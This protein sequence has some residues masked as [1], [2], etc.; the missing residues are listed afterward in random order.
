M[1]P[2]CTR[3]PR[4]S[5]HALPPF[6]SDCPLPAAG[7][8][9]GYLETHRPGISVTSAYW[10]Q[11]IWKLVRPWVDERIWRGGP[12]SYYEFFDAVFA[13]LYLLE[14]KK[15]AGDSAAD[16]RRVGEAKR[17]PPACEPLRSVGCTHPTN[18]RASAIEFLEHYGAIFLDSQAQEGIVGVGD[19]I[20]TFFEEESQRLR[21]DTMDI[22]GASVMHHQLISALAFVRYAKRRLHTPL[23][24]LGGFPTALDAWQVMVAFPF[25]DIAVFGDGE[26]TL[27]EICDAWQ[28]PDALERL[29]STVVR[30]AD[31][32]IE[33]PARG[34]VNAPDMAFANY[35]G[36][37]WSE[38]GQGN[39]SHLMLPICNARGCPWG[40]CGFCILNSRLPQDASARCPES[41]LAEVRQHLTTIR[42]TSA[43][44]IQVHFLGNEMLG[45][46][47]SI[48]DLVELFR[49]LVALRD[50]F[51]SLSILGEL[52]PVHLTDEVACL[53]NRLDATLQLGFE[54]WSR[55]VELAHKQHQ[56]IDGIHAL[57]LLERYPNLHLAGFNLLLGYPGET[58]ADVA[59]TKSNLWRLKYIL[60]ALARRDSQTTAEGGLFLV[61]P[62]TLRMMQVALPPEIVRRWDFD[63][64]FV[65]ENAAHRP[66]TVLLGMMCGDKAPQELAAFRED[67][68]PA[69]SR[70][71]SA[72]QE[73]RTPEA[74]QEPR[75][76]GIRN[77]DLILDYT[78]RNQFFEAYD[79]T[80][81]AGLQ[82]RLVARL[83]GLLQECSIEAYRNPAGLLELLLVAGRHRLAVPLEG[84]LLRILHETREIISRARLAERLA[85]FPSDEL[86]EGIAF[87]DTAELL[88]ISRRDG[89][90][91]NTLPAP[92]QAAVDVAAME[93][94]HGGEN[95]HDGSGT[96]LREREALVVSSDEATR[97]TDPA[98]CR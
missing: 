90:L 30:R 71:C 35:E 53:L 34:F 81:T 3:L 32:I 80:A 88:S 78:S 68:A 92:I 11:A 59:E 10:N 44:P 52:S 24:I 86:E 95:G 54:Q 77:G 7:Y 22:I 29:A 69:E 20:S 76:P 55:V 41:V 83:E 14:A 8:L 36:F 82:R 84:C 25:V 18:E 46:G 58:L 23:L 12:E 60:A 62:R 2:L 40:R 48:A 43:A 21:L 56:I 96:T 65:R 15:A 93:P 79:T 67:E 37:D 74:R 87:L 45:R 91:I 39:E 66:W 72:R 17:N 4:I 85:D 42:R 63:N 5:L 98:A 89:R 51:G 19:R 31:R 1:E 26:E 57:K 64:P 13:R 27:L 75:T 38:A 97:D 50:E 49:G 9:R 33:N 70:L 73:P 61:N 94:R 16:P 6:M 47:Q 28:D